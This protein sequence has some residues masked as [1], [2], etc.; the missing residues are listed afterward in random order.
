MNENWIRRVEVE[1]WLEFKELIDRRVRQSGTDQRT[2]AVFRGQSK[3]AWKLVASFDR[4]VTEVPGA[5]RVE[6][7][8][9]MVREARQRLIVA[10][11]IPEQPPIDDVDLAALLQHEGAQTRLLD[12]TASPYI[13]AFF[14]FSSVEAFGGKRVSEDG[15]S[16]VFELREDCDAVA[17]DRGMSVVRPSHQWNPRAAAQQGLFTMNRSPVESV[18]EFLALCYAHDDPPEPPLIKYVLPHTEVQHALRDLELMG[19]SSQSLFPGRMGIVRYSFY[20]ALDSGLSA[21]RTPV[22]P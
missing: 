13:A 7:H 1:T 4:A 16:A 9:Q 2:S 14:A 6:V 22:Q 8:D 5:A 20:R 10:Q 3:S 11:E 19:I 17:S 18:E 15:F 21:P 12:W